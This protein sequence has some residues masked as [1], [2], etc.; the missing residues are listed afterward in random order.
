MGAREKLNS[1]YTMGSLI[2]AGLLGWATGSWIIFIIAA[3]V[4]LG[5]GLNSG[6]IRPSK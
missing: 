1:A 3:A 6:D 5:L 2:V 4:L